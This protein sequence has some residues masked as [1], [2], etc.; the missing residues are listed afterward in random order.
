MLEYKIFFMILLIHYL[1]DFSLQT[2]YQAENKS[3]NNIA[4]LYHVLIYSATWLFVSYFFLFNLNLTT[5]LLFTIITFYSHFIT[6]YF[7]SRLTSSFFNKKDYHN[8]F[9]V[10]GFD[11]LLHY[12]TLFSTYEL[13]NIINLPIYAVLIIFCILVIIFV[14]LF[15]FDN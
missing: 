9:L 1:A 4:L 14:N 3:K 15:K 13:C 7:T 12:I 11:Q 10:V 8:G 5:A 6:D 2:S